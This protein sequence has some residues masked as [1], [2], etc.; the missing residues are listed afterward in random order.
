M[1]EMQTVVRMRPCCA[2]EVRWG[3]VLLEFKEKSPDHMGCVFSP[4]WCWGI[5]TSPSPV[6][7]S[8]V[9]VPR[10]FRGYAIA[11]SAHLWR[12]LTLDLRYGSIVGRNYAWLNLWTRFGSPNFI[13]PPQTC[14]NTM[15][16]DPVGSTRLLSRFYP[17]TWKKG[18]GT[19]RY[20]MGDCTDKYSETTG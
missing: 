2:A 5:G 8:N 20:S 10:D 17:C 4:I 16:V 11:S 19:F 14:C 15:G 7:K 3:A 9:V 13:Y 6:K 1:P 12:Q 18:C